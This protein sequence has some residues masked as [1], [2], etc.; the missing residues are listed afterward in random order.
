MMKKRMKMRIM[1]ENSFKKKS[2]EI[3]MVMS[4]KKNKRKKLRCSEDFK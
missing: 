3:S 4:K 2:K 1:K